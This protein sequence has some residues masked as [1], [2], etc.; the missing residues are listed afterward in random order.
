MTTAT[1]RAAEIHDVEDFSIV[2]L[3]EDEKP[4][5]PRQDGLPIFKFERRMGAHTWTCVS[6]EVSAPAYNQ[7]QVRPDQGD[8]GR[9]RAAGVSAVSPLRRHC[10]RYE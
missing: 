8:P 2:F 4:I 7:A 1:T 5:E 3:D 6:L 10:A 9:L